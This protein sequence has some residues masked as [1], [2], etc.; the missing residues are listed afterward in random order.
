MIFEENLPENK[1]VTRVTKIDLASRERSDQTSTRSFSRHC[2]IPRDRIFRR[3]GCGWRMRDRQVKQHRPLG[4]SRGLSL[5]VSQRTFVHAFLLILYLV[6]ATRYSK[7]SD[8]CNYLR[9]WLILV[10]NIAHSCSGGVSHGG[11]MSQRIL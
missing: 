5:V 8:F 2:A 3:R 9:G 1:K 7:V 6:C 11:A 10:D 4:R